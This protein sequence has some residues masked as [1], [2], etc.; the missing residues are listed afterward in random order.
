MKKN[1]SNALD[2]GS[3]EDPKG[4]KVLS[5]TELRNIK[6]KEILELRLEVKELKKQIPLGRKKTM[7]T[8]MARIILLN[9]ILQRKFLRA[10][11]NPRLLQF[12]FSIQM[13]FPYLILNPQKLKR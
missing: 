1:D 6:D 5:A 3:F 13:H 11:C 7:L 2:Y 8:T 9:Q 12:M 10:Q 4:N